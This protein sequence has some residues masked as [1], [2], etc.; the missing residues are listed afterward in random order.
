MHLG[1][2]PVSKL[3]VGNSYTE[4][5]LSAQCLPT[6][7][8]LPKSTVS[9]WTPI[10]IKA[11]I[12]KKKTKQ[13]KKRANKSCVLKKICST[14][15]SIRILVLFALT[16]STLSVIHEQGHERHY[17]YKYLRYHLL[18]KEKKIITIL[19]VACILLCIW[20]TTKE[21]NLLFFQGN[22]ST[23]NYFQT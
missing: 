3:R 7:E 19:Y 22:E 20:L 23:N 17:N 8:N 10:S 5:S 13:T 15:F 11:S 2:L 4:Q 9:C 16:H 1:N 21:Q 6:E 14:E 12:Y 18:I